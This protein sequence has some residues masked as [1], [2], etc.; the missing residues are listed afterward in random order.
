MKSRPASLD[1]I[2]YFTLATRIPIRA[3]GSQRRE[4]TI[5]SDT[6]VDPLIYQTHP[7][8]CYTAQARQI[9][10]VDAGT[11]GV[12]LASRHH[13]QKLGLSI[14]LIEVEPNVSVPAHLRRCT[15]V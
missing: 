4:V 12:A 3:L 7:N 1:E 6:E 13:Q 10:L 9:I 8:V 15:Y 14:L 5:P 11:A 2:E